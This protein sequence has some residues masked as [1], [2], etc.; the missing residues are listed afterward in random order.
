MEALRRTNDI[1][2]GQVQSLGVQVNR[3]LGK[4]NEKYFLDISNM[5]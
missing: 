1:F 5:I 4:T 2:H 3:L